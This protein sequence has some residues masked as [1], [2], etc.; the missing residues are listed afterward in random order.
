MYNMSK[1]YSYIFYADRNVRPWM[2]LGYTL[3]TFPKVVQYIYLCT[4]REEIRTLAQLQEK[5]LCIIGGESR[6]QVFYT[7]REKLNKDKE[8]RN[9][10]PSKH[11]EKDNTKLCIIF[12]FDI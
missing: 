6:Q 4:T 11:Q 5:K 8:G 2:I 12:L 3:A 10:Q 7:A 1:Y 9:S